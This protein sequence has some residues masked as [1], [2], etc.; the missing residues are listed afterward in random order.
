MIVLWHA[1]QSR[2]VPSYMSLTVLTVHAHADD[3]GGLQFSFVCLHVQTVH[4]LAQSIVHR[5][6]CSIVPLHLYIQ[7]MYIIGLEY[8]YIQS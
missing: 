2:C 7:R 5:S 8:V 6:E 3:K 4:V 1:V